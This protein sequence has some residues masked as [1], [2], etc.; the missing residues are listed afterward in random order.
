MPPPGYPQTSAS[1]PRRQA[2]AARQAAAAKKQIV[3]PAGSVEATHMNTVQRKIL[4]SKHIGEYSTL[5][6]TERE[7]TLAL[8]HRHVKLLL[9]CCR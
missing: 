9:Y 2:P 5:T 7:S 4:H 6:V 3:F 1:E 8:Y